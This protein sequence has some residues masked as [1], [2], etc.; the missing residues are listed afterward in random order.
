MTEKCFITLAP[1]WSRK[2]FPCSSPGT[3][4]WGYSIEPSSEVKKFQNRTW[5]KKIGIL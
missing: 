4:T 3:G 1:G 5:T 2:D